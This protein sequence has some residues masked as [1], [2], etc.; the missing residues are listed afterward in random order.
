MDKKNLVISA[1]VSL[2]VVLVVAPFFKGTVV[3]K[4]IER[5]VGAQPGPE[6]DDLVAKGKPFTA[7]P[8]VLSTTTNIGTAATLTAADITNYGYFVVTLGGAD[9][10]DFTYTLP[11]STTIANLV[12]GVGNKA[13]ISFFNQAS[14]SSEHLLIFAAGTGIDLEFATSSVA[15]LLPTPLGVEDG[16]TAL[17][18]FERQA[19]YSGTPGNI[20]ARVYLGADVD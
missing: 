17:I 6:I 7:A 5:I 11:A 16:D 15:G 13:S 8:N 14:S 19:T 12:P 18:E 2:A 1:I 20:T 3:E 4:T 10:A 9:E